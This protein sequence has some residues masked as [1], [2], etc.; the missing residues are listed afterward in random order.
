[1]LFCIVGLFLMASIWQLLC[2]ETL[3]LGY[4][5]KGSKMREVRE[6]EEEQHA[7]TLVCSSLLLD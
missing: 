7:N 5:R 2:T 6:M 4:A 1:M 3:L